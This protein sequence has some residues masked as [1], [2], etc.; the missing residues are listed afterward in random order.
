MLKDKKHTTSQRMGRVERVLSQLYLTNVSM[1]ERLDKLEK[2]LFKEE[3]KEN[4]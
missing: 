2:I 4:E 1:T 3:E